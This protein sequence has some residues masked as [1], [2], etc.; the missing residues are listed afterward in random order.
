MNGLALV[1]KID[2]DFKKVKGI[3]GVCVG[4]LR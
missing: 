1:K 4:W 2:L 3:L